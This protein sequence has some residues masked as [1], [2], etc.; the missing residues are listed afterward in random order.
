[1]GF[2][3]AARSTE[4]GSANLSGTAPLAKFSGSNALF[5]QR[6]SRSH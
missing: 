6:T 5:G 4:Q 2:D 1:M 3:L